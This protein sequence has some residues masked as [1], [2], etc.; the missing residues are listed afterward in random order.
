MIP[1]DLYPQDATLWLTET[2]NDSDRQLVFSVENT[3]VM[4]IIE[5]GSSTDNPSDLAINYFASLLARFRS[6]WLDGPGAG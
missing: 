2:S 3:R 6:K 4:R 1:L 5:A